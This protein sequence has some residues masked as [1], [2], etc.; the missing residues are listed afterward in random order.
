MEAISHTGDHR[1][2]P[3]VPY[4]NYRYY[5][6]E[7]LAMMGWSKGEMSEVWGLRCSPSIDE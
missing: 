7:K 3:D 1:V 2:P 4:E 5:I 6:R